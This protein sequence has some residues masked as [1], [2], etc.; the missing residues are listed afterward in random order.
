MIQMS[1]KKALDLVGEKHS[2]QCLPSAPLVE[3]VLAAG[4]QVCTM[5]TLNEWA[6]PRLEMG[7]CVF[8]G[9]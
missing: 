9:G 1:L 8:L 6:N 5:C 2:G 7:R 3:A 4:D